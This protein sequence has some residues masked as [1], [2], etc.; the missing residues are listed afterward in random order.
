MFPIKRLC[1]SKTLSSFTKT[2]SKRRFVIKTLSRIYDRR[3][4]QNKLT[5]L[6]QLIFTCSNS[7]IETLEKDV[8][9]VNDVNN[10][11]L[12]FLLLTLNIFHVFF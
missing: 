7:T 5:T 2:C 10:V 4:L 11:V 3:F 6:T 1:G 12:V 8:K 9:Y